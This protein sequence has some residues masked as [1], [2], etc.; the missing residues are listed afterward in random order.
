MSIDVTIASRLDELI[1]LGKRVLATRRPPPAAGI[2]TDDYIDAQLAN[3]WLV[4]CLN[5]QTHERHKIW[6]AAPPSWPDFLSPERPL[7]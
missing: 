5:R 4:S 6:P 7:H 3:Q 1:V 2:I